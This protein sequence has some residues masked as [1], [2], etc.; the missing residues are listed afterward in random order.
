MKISFAVLLGL[1]LLCGGA[2]ADEKKSDAKKSEKAKAKAKKSEKAKS[3]SSQ[4]SN[5]NVFQKA[6]SSTGKALH[7]SKI[8]TRNENRSR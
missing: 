2:Y 1:A 3:S 6:E 8:W 7:D 5:Q 4:Q